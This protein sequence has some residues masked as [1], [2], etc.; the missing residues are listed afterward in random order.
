ML[1]KI[2]T[3]V[4]TTDLGPGAP[5][6]F[7]YALAMARQHQAKIV[8]VH[9]MEPLSTFA[10]S[11]V[12]EYIP[13]NRAEEMQK[14]AR[15]SVTAKLKS[16]IEQL[17]AKEC[18]N[19]P[20][21]ENAVSSIYVV[22]GYPDQVILNVAK[23]CAADM[24]IMGTYNHTLVGEVIVGSTTRKVL[25]HATLPVLVIKIPKGYTEED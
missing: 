11:L 20:S 10:Q 12:G 2:E 1:P 3:I 6:V 19:V 17:C 13:H 5:F 24:I 4:Y 22:E 18:S 16:R 15:E 23:D 9:A 25:H 7:R 21:C 14:K 8:A